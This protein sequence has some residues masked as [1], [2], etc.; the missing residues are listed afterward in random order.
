MYQDNTASITMNKSGG[1]SFRR[2]KH[3]IV[4]DN[5]IKEHVD[6]NIVKQIWLA[7]DDMIADG[8]TKP[9]WGSEFSNFVTSLH[10][11]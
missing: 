10:M 6:N 11:T 7:T 4:R 2:S 9:K 8:G 3:M 1:G 5:F